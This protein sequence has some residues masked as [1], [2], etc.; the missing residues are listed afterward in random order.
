MGLYAKSISFLVILHD[1]GKAS[2][3]DFGWGQ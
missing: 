2:T 1:K 3:I